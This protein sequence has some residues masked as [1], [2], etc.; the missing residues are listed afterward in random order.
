MKILFISGG[1][2]I[3]GIS[4]SLLSLLKVL[5]KEDLDVA[6]YL[7]ERTPD[8]LARIPKGVHLAEI[9][10][11]DKICRIPAR[12]SE[13]LKFF[14]QRRILINALCLHWHRHFRSA[15]K[16]KQRRLEMHYYQ[17]R[18]ER[19]SRSSHIHID[20]SEEYDAVISWG[21]LLTNYVLANNIR[22]GKKFGWIHP[23]YD[24]AGFDAAID[25]RNL[26]ALDGIVAVSEAGKKSLIRNF[27]EWENKIFAINNLINTEEIRELSLQNPGIVAHDGLTFVTVARIQNASKAFDR[28]LRIA[29]RLCQKGYTFSW[30]VVGDGEDLAAM[31][32]AAR[33]MGLE[34]CVGFLGARK[35][36][37]PYVKAAD[38]F[39]LQSYYEGRP[40]VVDEALILGTPVIVTSYPAAEQQVKNGAEGL[41]VPN[42]EEEILSAL[43]NVLRNPAIIQQWKENLRAKDLG[44][45]GRSA[46]FFKMLGLEG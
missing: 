20:L 33:Q 10:E 19:L 11:L 6:L 17:R 14:F 44:I 22:C 5:L 29:E 18:D 23:D 45:F 28:A 40:L 12:R 38:L 3:G 43:E 35:N 21:E 8:T 42:D 32:E 37:Y 27:P 7:V 2:Q 39:V 30:Y 15:D 26:S 16:E 13:K 36:P 9:P 34:D 46:S 24:G 41:I 4:S 31:K 25:R 1:L